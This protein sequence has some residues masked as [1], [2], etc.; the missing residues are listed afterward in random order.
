MNYLSI[1]SLIQ[2]GNDFKRPADDRLSIEVSKAQNNIPADKRDGN[3]MVGNVWL[4]IQLDE[5]KSS[6]RG[7]CILRQETLLNELSKALEEDKALVV[8]K[9]EKLRTECILDRIQN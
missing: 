3:F 6:V 9:F 2:K 5:Q 7:A 1:L 4:M 8:S